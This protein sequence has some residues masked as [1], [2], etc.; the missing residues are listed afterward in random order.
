MISDTAVIMQMFHENICRNLNKTKATAFFFFCFSFIQTRDQSRS[1]FNAVVFNTVCY[2]NRPYI[3][4][5]YRDFAL[6]N[7]CM[8]AVKVTCE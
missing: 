3:V 1:T 7:N 6:K 4:I 8:C 5:C 2:L